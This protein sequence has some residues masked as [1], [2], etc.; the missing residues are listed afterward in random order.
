M[1]LLGSRER[2]YLFLVWT[3]VIDGIG[4]GV[5]FVGQNWICVE[6]VLACLVAFLS[7]WVGEACISMGLL[8]CMYVP[9]MGWWKTYT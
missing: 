9:W 7:F 1:E 2:F 3:L 6:F 5:G 4:V 8:G